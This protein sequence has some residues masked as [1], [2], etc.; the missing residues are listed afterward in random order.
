M[1]LPLFLDI[2]FSHPN[3]RGYPIALSWSLSDGQLKYALVLPDDSWSPHEAPPEEMSLQHLYDQGF[4]GPDIIRELQEDLAGQTVFVDGLDDDQSGIDLLFETYGE[5]T[6][7][8]IAG[9]GQLFSDYSLEELLEMK[10]NQMEE[11]GLRGES[12]EDGVL[13]LLYLARQLGEI[14]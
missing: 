3:E 5:E 6:N 10:R 4:A 13:S 8:E 1:T 12:A 14:D 7:F 2:E 11:L 9:I